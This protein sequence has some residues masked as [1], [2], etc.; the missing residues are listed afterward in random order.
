MNDE[1]GRFV[2][3]QDGFVLVDY[4]DRDV[5]RREPFLR[6]PGF[7]ELPVS[8][9][10]GRRGFLTVDEQV[11]V[12]DQALH[13]APAQVET[14]RGQPVEAFSGFR[15]LYIEAFG[16]HPAMRGARTEPRLYPRRRRKRLAL[17]TRLSSCS[18]SPSKNS[19]E[20]LSRASEV[21]SRSTPTSSA[22]SGSETGGSPNCCFSSP[23]ADG[24]GS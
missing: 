8:D 6:Q 20:R 22:A 2:H 18:S 23:A 1:T 10:V 19:C 15:G 5:L 16:R 12:S 14:P 7:Y 11:T 17:K 4:R 3:D 9:L 13:E 24:S 21:S